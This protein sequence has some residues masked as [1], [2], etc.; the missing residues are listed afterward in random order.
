MQDK[1]LGMLF[2]LSFSEFVTT[3]IIKFLFILGI[4]SAAIWALVAVVGGFREGV[5]KGLLWL[6][7][8]PVI[9][10]FLVFVS[11]VWCELIIV[12]FRIAENTSRLVEQGRT[13]VKSTE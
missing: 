9:F 2:D 12:V 6:V 7:L 10:L 11:R 4:I 3:R 13:P 5:G 8:S 1:G